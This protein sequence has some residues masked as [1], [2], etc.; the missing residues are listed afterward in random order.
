MSGIAG[1]YNLDGQAVDRTIIQKMAAA[2]AQRGPD[3]EGLWVQGNVGLGH[4]QLRTTP[5]SQNEHQP[6]SIDDGNYVIT[7]DARVDNRGELIQA[8]QGRVPV[9]SETSDAELLLRAYIAWGPDGI[10]RVVGD[11]ALGIW[12]GRR[13]QLFCARDPMGI[14]TLYYYRHD[15][16]FIFASD[17]D[18]IFLGAEIPRELNQFMVALYLLGR[19]D[20]AEQTFFKGVFR[21]LPANHVVISMRGIR[22]QVY[23]EPTP[24][25]QIKYA[26][27]ED[28]IDHFRQVF[29]EAVGCRLRGITPIGISLSGGKDSTSI[30][31]TAAHLLSQ[32]SVPSTEVEAFS[33]V[34]KDFPSADE[35]PYIQ[36]VL[37]TSG[38]RGHYV[39]GD[40]HWGFKP[41]QNTNL[42]WNWPYPIAL[43]ANQEA[44]LSCARDLGFRV[45]LTGEGGDEF[46]NAGYPYLVDLL[47][48][49]RW[50]RLREELSYLTAQER[51]TFRKAAFIH[52]KNNFRNWFPEPV[53]KIYGRLRPRAVPKWLNSEFIRQSGAL[54]YEELPIAHKSRSLYQQGE[55]GIAVILAR[56]PFL[57]FINEIYA[58]HHVEARHPFLDLRVVEFLTRVPPHIKYARGSSKLLLRQAMEGL[59]PDDVRLR[60]VK[61]NFLGPV[62]HGMREEQ[63]RI[64]GMLED[65]YLVASGWVNQQA[66]LSLYDQSLANTQGLNSRLVALITLEEWLGHYFGSN[67][68]GVPS[69]ELHLAPTVGPERR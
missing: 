47:K 8:L 69:R 61:T 29:D 41:L 31:C 45:I 42:H 5:E 49:G 3:E 13:Q 67:G 32:G 27:R 39:Y 16:R 21:L 23:W 22:K 25:D 35:S 52:Y 26:K 48:G 4:R 59:V 43:Q 17:I 30:A 34:Y 62:I 54:E 7:C 37:E 50:A 1:I 65:G 12:D 19:F 53:Q 57:Q 33:S 55:Y 63:A 66:I 9:S 51:R 18:A 20:E 2:V 38:I 60:D 11:F 44:R 14:R 6:I 10:K 56:L 46:H 24:R 15:S 68:S 58:Y 28:Y 64:K 36:Q 40:E